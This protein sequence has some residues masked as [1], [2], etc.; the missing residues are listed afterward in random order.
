[1]FSR[2]IRYDLAECDGRQDDSVH[3]KYNVIQR[4]LVAVTIML[5][6]CATLQARIVTRHHTLSGTFQQQGASYRI[7]VELVPTTETN[8]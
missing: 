8:S 7:H 1:M 6:L 3:G 4:N 2:V 5:P